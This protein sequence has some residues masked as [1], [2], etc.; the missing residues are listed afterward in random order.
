MGRKPQ[1]TALQ[2][3]HGVPGKR[4]LRPEPRVGGPLGPPPA[5]LDARS[6]RIW[7]EL[8]EIIPARVAA[9]SDRMLPKLQLL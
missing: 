9:R 6:K 2:A 5:C 4:K 1:P 8:R 7:E 3:L